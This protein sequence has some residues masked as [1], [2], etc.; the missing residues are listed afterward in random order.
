MDPRGDALKRAILAGDDRALRRFLDEHLRPLYAFCHPRLGRDHHATEEVVQETLLLALE[1]M[2]DYDPGRG[3]LDTWLAWLSR[4]V[5]R[6]AQTRRK[7]APLDD[8]VPALAAEVDRGPLVAAAL[9]RLPDHYRGVL[10]RKYLRGEPV[11]TIASALGTTEKAIES[12]LVRAR[13]AFRETYLAVRE[14]ET[15][16]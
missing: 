4:N 8:D 10:E 13:D 7:V 16:S 15:C 3:D 9:A 2:E 6:R 5:I 12:L 1:R 14:A 11:R